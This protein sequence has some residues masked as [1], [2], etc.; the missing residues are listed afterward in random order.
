MLN[1]KSGQKK[2]TKIDYLR[3]KTGVLLYAIL[4]GIAISL[5][6]TVFL[7]L[8]DA[9]P[10][11]N[12]VGALL[13]TIGLFVICTR[14]YNLFTGKACY[15]PENKPRY[16]IN[17][18]II[19]I[20]NLLGC[21]L[22][23]GLERL[24][25]ICGETGINQA[26]TGMIDAKMSASLISL[27]ILGFL[28]NIFIFIA[29]DGFKNNKHELGKY[30]ALFLGVSIF[31][32]CGTEHSVADMYYWSV[33][34]TLFAHFGTSILRIVIISLG[35]VLGGITFPLIEKAKSKLDQN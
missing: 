10:G 12:V 9:F 16:I 29:V 17:L 25:G 21:M 2:T 23:A 26:A 4:A 7:R 34:G 22:V 1:M 33:S 3:E 14:G 35:N 15:I 20:G 19:W 6:G 5:G 27:F 18:G 11:G 31:I 24:T 13:F 30:L 8:K 28:C 32:L